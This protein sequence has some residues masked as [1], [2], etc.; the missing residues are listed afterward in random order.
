MNNKSLISNQQPLVEESMKNGKIVLESSVFGYVNGV[1][2]K[3]KSRF[4]V[5]L[6]TCFRSL[7]YQKLEDVCGEEGDCYSKRGFF[8]LVLPTGKF[9]APMRRKHECIIGPRTRPMKSWMVIQQE[10]RGRFIHIVFG[11]V[12]RRKF[13]MSV[14][15]SRFGVKLLWLTKEFMTK[16]GPH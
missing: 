5:L 8:E 2:L 3:S 15:R 6:W 4:S 14:W 11:K 7:L 10:K 13:E 1:D 12:S 16:G 9:P